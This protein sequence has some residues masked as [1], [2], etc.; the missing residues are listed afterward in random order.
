MPLSQRHQSLTGSSISATGAT[1]GAPSVPLEPLWQPHQCHTGSSISA[2]GATQAAPS[3]PHWDLHQCQWCHSGSAISA[4]GAYE[5]DGGNCRRN[6][7][8][9]CAECGG[10]CTG[11]RCWTAPPQGTYTEAAAKLRLTTG[12]PHSHR[13][14]SE[15]ALLPTHTYYGNLY[16]NFSFFC[17]GLCRARLSDSY[18]V[19]TLNNRP[20]LGLDICRWD[21][22]LYCAL[23]LAPEG[24]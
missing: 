11:R 18:D 6:K 22:Y 23:T 17:P 14:V 4:T 12:A 20:S 21:V 5:W 10:S 16:Y 9:L 15:A 3:V 24:V 19:D 13:G 1:P 2:N 8:P 7:S